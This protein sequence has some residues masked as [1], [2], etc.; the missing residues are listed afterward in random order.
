MLELVELILVLG[1][2]GNSNTPPLSLMTTIPTDILRKAESTTQ[3]QYLPLL[4]KNTA[5]EAGPSSA[6]AYPAGRHGAEQSSRFDTVLE[7]LYERL[8]KKPRET[9]TRIAVHELGS[10]DWAGP[11]GEVRSWVSDNNCSLCSS[12]LS[13]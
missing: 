3:L 12:L 11:D 8:D 2:V 7:Q 4:T 9:A 1:S 10:M 6:S 13:S 5:D